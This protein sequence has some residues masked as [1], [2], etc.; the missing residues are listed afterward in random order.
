MHPPDIAPRVEEPPGHV[1]GILYG[2][3][4]H[5]CHEGHGG[6]A[7]SA[8]A[9]AGRRQRRVEQ[10][11]SFMWLL[12]ER[13]LWRELKAVNCRRYRVGC[14]AFAR[15][16]E[17]RC[18]SSHVVRG[19]P[20]MNVPKNLRLLGSVCYDEHWSAGQPVYV[21]ACPRTAQRSMGGSAPRRILPQ[22][23]GS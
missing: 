16:E 15:Q 14:R 20:A 22:G 11:E 13:V 1:H 17:Q 23:P 18:Y 9:T 4:V 3:W 7:A 8:S 5:V 19:S 12:P 2:A 6:A 21:P 10:Q